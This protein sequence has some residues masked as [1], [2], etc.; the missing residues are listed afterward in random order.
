MCLLL[1]HL[2]VPRSVAAAVGGVVLGRRARVRAAAELV[3]ARRQRRRGARARASSGRSQRR[4][5][6]SLRTGPA[7]PLELMTMGM[8]A[9]AIPSWTMT[10]GDN[11]TDKAAGSGGCAGGF[12]VRRRRRHKGR[13]RGRGG[14]GGRWRCHCRRR[15]WQG[16]R[17]A[18]GGWVLGG[19]GGLMGLRDQVGQAAR[20]ACGSSRAT[21]PSF[22]R[23]ARVRAAA[24][25]VTARRPRRRGARKRASSERSRRPFACGSSRA[26]RLS[27]RRS[28]WSLRGRRRRG[29]S[30]WRSS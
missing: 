6:A 12:E 29:R 27:S 23:R 2:T 30:R 21:R 26:K 9:S 5:R 4:P 3:T 18:G 17:W 22:R 11:R 16:P 20:G 7:I 19:Q 10:I 13:R 24:E 25:L 8:P 15:A 14:G 1:G 28:W